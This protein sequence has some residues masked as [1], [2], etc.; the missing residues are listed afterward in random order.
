MID[1]YI[2]ENKGLVAVIKIFGADFRDDLS[3]FKETIP[4]RD[5]EWKDKEKVWYVREPQL[6]THIRAIKNA[7]DIHKRQGRMFGDE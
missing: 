1:C 7:L 3:Y 5:R 6:Y 4:Y 2:I